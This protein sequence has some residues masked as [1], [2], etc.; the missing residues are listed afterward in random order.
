MIHYTKAGVRSK[1]TRL[2]HSVSIETIETASAAICRKIMSMERIFTKTTGIVVYAAI[3][4]EIK[5]DKLVNQVL[6][7]G[8]PVY[9]PRYN[10]LIKQYNIVKIND[11][12]TDLIPGHLGILEPKESL[13]S[14]ESDFDL[15][16]LVWLVPGIAFDVFGGRIGRGKGFYDSLLRRYSGQKIGIGYDWQLTDTVPTTVHDISLDSLITEKRYLAFNA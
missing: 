6:P 11:L 3:Q 12:K 1:F 4:F 8:I 15:S 13:S 9:Y 14:S 10:D 16:Q 7:E 2:L 5:L